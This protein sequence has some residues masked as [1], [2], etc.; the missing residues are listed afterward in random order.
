MS[1]S[2]GSLIALIILLV[3]LLLSF[4][5]LAVLGLLFAAI[6]GRWVLAVCI[7]IFLDLLWGTPT[8]FFHFLLLPWTLCACV[9]VAFRHML[10]GRIRLR[11]PDR[12]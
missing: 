5:P 11:M 1:R 2:I 3:G 7:G 12:L 9:V 8:G 6:Q 4:W 10:L